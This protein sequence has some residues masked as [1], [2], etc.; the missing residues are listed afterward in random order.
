MHAHQFADRTNFRF[1]DLYPILLLKA[2]TACM[3]SDDYHW[4][5]FA[6]VPGN[7]H[8]AVC[9]LSSELPDVSLLVLQTVLTS[10][11]L[12]SITENTGVSQHWLS[13]SC[14]N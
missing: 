5:C 7:G 3:C 6:D 10:P 12:K 2:T 11:E 13:T 8:L 9:V 4:Q 1:A 14:T